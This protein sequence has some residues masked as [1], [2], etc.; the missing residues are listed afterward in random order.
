M[1]HFYGSWSVAM[2]IVV[3][4]LVAI[5]APGV[6]ARRVYLQARRLQQAATL[7]NH[8]ATHDAL[9]D[10]PNRST[11]I[12]RLRQLTRERTDGQLLVAVMLVDLDRFKPVNDSL[13]CTIGDAVLQEVA[14]RLRLIV[15]QDGEVARLGADEFLVMAQLPGTRD[16]IRMAGRIVQRLGQAYAVGPA[17]LHLAAS[18]GATTFPFDNSVADVL[19]SHA[20]EAM[21]EAKHCGGNGYCVFVPGT[22]VYTPDR[23]EIENDLWHAVERGQ[24]EVWY[25][26]QV[27]VQ[28]GRIVGLEA[29]ARWR[30][31][32]RGMI[33]P[34]VFVPI[35]ETSDIIQQLGRWIMDDVC[36]Q[37]SAWRQEGFD[38][39]R[40]AVN[41][42][43][44]Q[45]RQPDL[46]AVIQQALE[47]NRLEPRHI[48]L[49]VTESSVMSDF[50]RTR[51]ILEQLNHVGMRVAIDDFGTGCSSMSYLRQLPVNYL[52]ID[53]SLISEL[54]SNARSD[55][56]VKAVIDLAHGMGMSTI[57][58]GVESALQLGSLRQFGCD[59][60][61]G[62]YFS[63]ALPAS[64]VS[65]WLRRRPRHLS[66][67]ETVQSLLESVGRLA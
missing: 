14:A 50:A 65:A 28:S 41:L 1:L 52:K 16:V 5:V 63:R 36:R 67:A 31:P 15:G 7:L 47:R 42:S 54:G 23:I 27:D 6:A 58:E 49:E 33:P 10:L 56:I 35:A 24:L 55:A 37:V 4:V 13:G 19:V 66:D 29:L 8:Q 60:Y 25:Q 57:A 61:Q 44:R 12:E 40:V 38:D 30:H 26:P 3:V 46:A 64:D 20:D 39:I 45:F 2:S 53:R 34:V 59:Q 21:Y 11:F 48:E 43:A 22:T 17:E 51:E 9:T 62:F 32:T 18:V